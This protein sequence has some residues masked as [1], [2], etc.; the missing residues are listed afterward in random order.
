MPERTEQSCAHSALSLSLSP[1]SL[2]SQQPSPSAATSVAHNTRPQRV[3]CWKRAPGSKQNVPVRLVWI[4]TETGLPRR[5][6]EA[7]LETHHLTWLE[8]H[9]HQRLL[10]PESCV[11]AGFPSGI[12]S[13]LHLVLQQ[14]AV[15]A[16]LARLHQGA[17]GVR[18][19]PSFP[20]RHHM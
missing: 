3:R 9:L 13:A 16:L 2:T 8:A 10:P 19:A 18:K 15:P 5:S 12:G 6:W 20:G 1:K 4:E 7:F 11:A 14:S 17:H